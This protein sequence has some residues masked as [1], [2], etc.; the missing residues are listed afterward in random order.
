LSY[1]PPP[2]YIEA[3]ELKTKALQLDKST[4]AA[5][6]LSSSFS[7]MLNREKSPDLFNPARTLTSDRGKVSSGHRDLFGEA[8]GNNNNNKSPSRAP[9]KKRLG[10]PESLSQYTVC[11]S[12]SHEATMF[13]TGTLQE[14][15]STAVGQQ[16]LVF[17]FVTGEAPSGLADNL[18]D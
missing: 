18:E 3:L 9:Q 10:K 1:I 4:F 8:L 15:I 12:I 11:R 5:R 14:G 7:C 16:K 17:C 2:L 13:Y 6:F